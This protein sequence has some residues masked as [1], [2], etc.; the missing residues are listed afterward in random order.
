MSISLLIF[1]TVILEELSKIMCVEIFLDYNCKYDY[2]TSVFK[3]YYK[4]VFL[5]YIVL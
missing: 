4:I 2:I 5:I 3:E 1:K